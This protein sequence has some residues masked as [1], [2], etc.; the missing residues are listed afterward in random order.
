VNHP[1]YADG[2]P[3]VS[4]CIANYN[5]AGIIAECIGSA[6]SQ[7]CDFPVEIIVHDDASTDGSV[8]FIRNNF[9]LVRLITSEMNVGFCVSNNRMADAALGQFIL[10][11]N[12]DATLEPNA[13]ATLHACAQRQQPQ[14]I[15]SLPQ[16]DWHTGALVDRGCLIDPF[17]NPVPNQDAK[18]TDITM[19]IGACLW[20][21]RGLWQELGG[22]PDWFESIAEDLYLCCRAR[23]AGYPV[24]VT[25][26]SGYRHLQGKSF[27]GNRAAEGRLST[28][29]RRRRLSERNKTFVMIICSPP[30]R[31][32]LTLPIHLVLLV[33]EGTVLSVVKHEWR[34]WRDIY[35][36]SL[37]GVFENRQKLWHYRQQVEET[38]TKRPMCPR[39]IFSYMPRKLQMLVRYGLPTFSK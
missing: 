32:L 23:V 27:G 20:I 2:P 8:D 10:L 35:A 1:R 25:S 12:N 19:V 3:L 39:M 18:R 34:I 26:A 33:L 22:F 31:L 37:A 24:Q 17:F 5:G 36:W 11:L 28:T 9:P 14:G 30:L 6:L 7:D 13:L 29:Y 38:P 15:L 21:P 4:V 16:Y